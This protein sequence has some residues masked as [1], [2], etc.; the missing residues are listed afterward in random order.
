MEKLTGAIT[1]NYLKLAIGKLCDDLEDAG[2]ESLAMAIPDALNRLNN[3]IEAGRAA[4]AKEQR[5]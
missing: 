1:L 4:L 2:Y 3:A 5:E